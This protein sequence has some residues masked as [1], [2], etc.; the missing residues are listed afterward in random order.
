MENFNEILSS[1][2]SRFELTNGL[3]KTAIPY[4]SILFCNRHNFLLP[5]MGNPYI[6][7]VVDGNMRLYNENGFC[8]Y[9][10]GQYFISAIDRP[11]TAETFSAVSEN[12]F[13]PLLSE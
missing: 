13:D 2:I 4:I 7:L 11:R 9:S 1:Y 6:L 8:D 3:N 5:D 10:P 12:T